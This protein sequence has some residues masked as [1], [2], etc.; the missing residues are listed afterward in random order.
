M[1]KAAKPAVAATVA[2]A[3]DSAAVQRKL[4]PIYE[5]VDSRNHKAALKAIAQLLTKHPSAQIGRVLKGIVLQR[6]GKEA[7]GLQLCEEVRLEG[8][9]DDTVLNT[10]ALFYKNTGRRAE[11]LAMYEAAADK[12]PKN[13]DHLL[14]L[15]AAYARDFVFVKQQQCAM[16]LYRLTNDPKHIMWAVCSL[17]LQS[18]DAD[19]AAA[20]AAA[21]ISIDA[22]AAVSVPVPPSA[23]L[24]LA[25]G[26]CVKL[27]AAGAIDNREALLVYARVLR[28]SGRGL[29]A[30]ELLAGALG[31][32]CVPMLAERLSLCA[33]QAAALGMSLEAATYWRRVL[34]LAPDDWVA[35]SA[36]LDIAMPGTIPSVAS[37]PPAPAGGAWACPSAHTEGG[38][39][40]GAGGSHLTS[41]PHIQSVEAVAAGATLVAELRAAADAAGGAHQAGRGAY[42]LTVEFAWRQQQLR[43]DRLPGAGA[44]AAT[45]AE[46][47]ADVAAEAS[48]AGAML[49]YWRGFGA[50]TSCARDLQPY[51]D[52]LTEGGGEGGAWLQGQLA[53]GAA[54]L[55]TQLGKEEQGKEHGEGSVEK[56]AVRQLRRAVAAEAICAHLGSLGGSWRDR[57]TGCG[58]RGEIVVDVRSGRAVLEH[59]FGR[60]AAA[61]FM[62]RYRSA[63]PLVAGADPREPTPADTLALLATQALAAEASGH[64][65]KAAAAST[66]PASST[67]ASATA[68]AAAAATATAD[69]AAAAAA[70]TLE[71]PSPDVAASLGEATLALLSAA[72][73]AAEGL[74][75]SPN[76]AEL[77]LGLTSIYALLG[78][79]TASHDAFAP[80]DCK[81][82][83]MDTMVHHILPAAEVG[84]GTLNP[85]P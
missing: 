15:F 71:C 5:M 50:W 59:G 65:A 36:A 4:E 3:V 2:A 26:M 22:A 10:L 1:G 11:S 78:A 40:T 21:A 24:Q 25:A 80:L 31:E 12:A 60:A 75:A 76:H 67:A 47:G 37:K 32:R 9:N 39:T 46:I 66:S 7:E 16:K 54:Q 83:Q 45:G 77:R 49:E 85:K 17:L 63:R 44:D 51:C 38:V 41:A 35:M 28:E 70:A 27:E 62:N 43:E 30:L 68:T 79:A 34:E 20:A 8:T 82:I 64:A 72:A 14:V 55:W 23:M 58:I 13:V 42:L 18:R 52:R 6:T 33:I 69:D 81:N 48:L 57:P 56:E 74:T 53:S 19:A 29:K 61:G 84:R 73:V